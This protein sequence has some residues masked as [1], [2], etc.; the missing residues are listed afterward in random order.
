[1]EYI[2]I[3]NLS[4]AFD[5][6]WHSNGLLEKAAEHIKVWV[7]DLKIKG[8]KTEVIKIND[9]SPIIFTEIEGDYD[10]TIFFYGHYD[11]QPPFTGWFEGMGATIPVIKDGKLYGRGG[12][13]DGYATYSTMIAIK[14]IQ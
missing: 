6:E 3:P 5:P 2:K 11:K 13:D 4:R 8:C 12:A 9:L 7:E 1:M 10:E 14:A